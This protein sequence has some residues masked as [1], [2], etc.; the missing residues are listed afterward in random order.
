[1]LTIIKQIVNKCNITD[2]MALA[3]GSAATRCQA[4][5]RYSAFIV[6]PSIQKGALLIVLS[7]SSHKSCVQAANS[8]KAGAIAP[9]LLLHFFAENH[10]VNRLGRHILILVPRPS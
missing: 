1:M 6:H 4:L 8:N 9:A 2:E 7:F 10:G 3:A 5:L